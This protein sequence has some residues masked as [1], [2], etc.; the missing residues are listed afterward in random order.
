MGESI[1]AKRHGKCRMCQ[2]ENTVITMMTFFAE[3]PEECGIVELDCQ[4]VVVGFHEKISNPPGNNANGAVYIFEPEVVEDIVNCPE[5]Y[6]DISTDIL[7]SYMGKIFAWPADGL[8]IDIGTPSC[9][10]EANLIVSERNSLN[11]D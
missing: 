8:H 3:V 5:S 1:P 7:P 11:T 10:A 4:S 6:T 9:L 2:A